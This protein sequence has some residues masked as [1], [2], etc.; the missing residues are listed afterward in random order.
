MNFKIGW[1]DEG[2]EKRVNEEGVCSYSQ[3]LSYQL[4]ATMSTFY[5]PLILI[6]FLYWKIFQVILIF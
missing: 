1:K 6:L 3:D 5:A 2:F 4:F